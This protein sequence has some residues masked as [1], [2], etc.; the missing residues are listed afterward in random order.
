MRVKK[1]GASTSGLAGPT[2]GT[3]QP[4]RYFRAGSIIA[5]QQPVLHAHDF[6]HAARQVRVVRAC[7]RLTPESAFNPR[8]RSSTAWAVWR[9]RLPV[10]VH[11]CTAEEVMCLSIH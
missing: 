6:L 5:A 7:R 9:S 4:D 2:L 8:M 3:K 1:H 10:L 11:E